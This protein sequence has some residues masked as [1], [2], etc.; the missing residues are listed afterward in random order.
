MKT[1][2]CRRLDRLCWL[3]VFRSSD[4]ASLS[5]PRAFVLDQVGSG[6]RPASMGDLQAPVCGTEPLDLQRPL[7]PYDDAG[8][9]QAHSETESAG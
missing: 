8:G 2:T 3:P 7:R 4:T 9:I 5:I 1:R 6:A